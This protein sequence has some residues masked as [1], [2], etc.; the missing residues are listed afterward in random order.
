[1]SV[2]TN[3]RLIIRSERDLKILPA[4]LE[5]KKYNDFFPWLQ[6]ALGQRM[7]GLNFK[8]EDGKVTPMGLIVIP[9][10]GLREDVIK[11]VEE[12]MSA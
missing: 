11:F 7:I 2:H 5:D 3:K 8:H 9:D 1:M 6:D 12:Y 10:P 4:W